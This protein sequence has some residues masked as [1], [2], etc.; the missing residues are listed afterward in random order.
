M[1]IHRF[2]KQI[3]ECEY[4]TAT[5]ICYVYYNCLESSIMNRMLRILCTVAPV[6]NRKRWTDYHKRVR[7]CI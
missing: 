4:G 5:E 7:W 1:S 6:R 2:Y 3:E